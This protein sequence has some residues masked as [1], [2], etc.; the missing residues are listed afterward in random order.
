G[1]A[2]QFVQGASY[3]SLG[4]LEVGTEA[5]VGGSHLRRP[6]PR[7]FTTTIASTA[8]SPAATAATPAPARAAAAGS[9]RRR[10][11]GIPCL[12]G[13]PPICQLLF[14]LAHLGAQQQEVVGG[15]EARMGEQPLRTLALAL[16]EAWLQLED[17]DHGSGE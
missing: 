12:Q 6:L 17:L 13:G 4:T 9:G 8:A 16:G 2:G 11:D 15:A 14:H 10:R 7:V 3:L 1:H 5:H